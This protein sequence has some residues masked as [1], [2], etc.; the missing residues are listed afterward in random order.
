MNQDLGI[1]ARPKHMTAMAKLL[2]EELEVVDLAVERDPDRAI[3][4]GQRLL[5]PGQVD[6]A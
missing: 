4:I 2:V 6:D 5:A 3:F 1:A